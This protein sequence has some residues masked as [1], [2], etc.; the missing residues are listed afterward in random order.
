MNISISI[1]INSENQDVI[2]NPIDCAERALRACSQSLVEALGDYLPR[3][4]VEFTDGHILRDVNGNSIGAAYV[5]VRQEDIEERD[6]PLDGS[7]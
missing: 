7:Y 1:D 2:D 5:E 6:G 3:N 4:P